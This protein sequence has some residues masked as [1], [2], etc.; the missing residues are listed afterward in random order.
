MAAQE[1]AARSAAAGICATSIVAQRD[2]DPAAGYRSDAACCARN[3]T[4]V[5]TADRPRDDPNHR[6]S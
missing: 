1:D 2:A 3:G 6:P 4:L 5:E